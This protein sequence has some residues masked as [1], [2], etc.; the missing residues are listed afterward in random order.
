MAF[1]LNPFARKLAGLKRNE[2]E[3]HSTPVAHA[4]LEDHP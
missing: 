1:A 4:D 3:R 2:G